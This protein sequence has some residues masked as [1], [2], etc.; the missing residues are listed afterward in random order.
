LCNVEIKKLIKTDYIPEAVVEPSTPVSVVQSTPVQ[1]QQRGSGWLSNLNPFNRR[2]RVSP[3]QQQQPQQGRRWNPL[4]RLRRVAPSANSFG[5]RYNADFMNATERDLQLLRDQELKYNRVDIDCKPCVLTNM[6]KIRTKLG[7]DV[8]TREKA[9]SINT[10][11]HGTRNGIENTSYW[12][13]TYN[14]TGGD[15][16]YNRYNVYM[17]LKMA[18]QNLGKGTDDQK[19]RAHVLHRELSDRINRINDINSQASVS[20]TSFGRSRKRAPKHA[21][22]KI[23]NDIRYL[24]SI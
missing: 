3:I 5:S 8:L 4:S 23:D 14:L 21:H 22:K 9:D 15:P 24:R 1:P 19:Q 10:M 11:A 12:T 13:A 7:F 6:N 16:M 17:W 2:S 18:D 20:P